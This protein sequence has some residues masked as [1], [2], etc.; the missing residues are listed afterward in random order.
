MVS[1]NYKKFQI[2]GSFRIA[3][4][5]IMYHF[6]LNVEGR[7]SRPVMVCSNFITIRCCTFRLLMYIILYFVKKL[8]VRL[9][10]LDEFRA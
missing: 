10:V 5:S 4:W 7:S 3:S 8:K 2:S 9:L 6:F 1:V